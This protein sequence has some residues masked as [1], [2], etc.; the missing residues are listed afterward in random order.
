MKK[1]VIFTTIAT[2]I[3]LS[4]CNSGGATSSNSLQTNSTPPQVTSSNTNG[5]N[6]NW[7]NLNMNAPGSISAQTPQ[8]GNTSPIYKLQSDGVTPSYVVYTDSNNLYVYDSSKNGWNINLAT[9]PNKHGSFNH[10]SAG[11]N[12]IGGLATVVASTDQG[13]VYSYNYT[14]NIWSQLQGNGWGQLINTMDVAY[15][16]AGNL[17]NVVVGLASSKDDW[18]YG[19][20]EY[21]SPNGNAE[22]HGTGWQSNVNQ[23]S[24]NRDESGNVTNVVVGLNNGSVEA[25][26]GTLGSCADN[27]CWNELHNNGWRAAV[28]VMK[29]FFNSGSGQGIR[30]LVGLSN[31]AV[32]FY[33]S[34]LGNNWS[35]FQNSGWQSGVSYINTADNWE[36]QVGNSYSGSFV[37]GLNNGAIEY[38]NADSAHFTELHDSSWNS[39][40]NNLSAVW[41]GNLL[42]N[43]VIGLNN[44]AIEEYYA[45]FANLN[46]NKITQLLAATGNSGILITSF[47]KYGSLNSINNIRGDRNWYQYQNT[48]AYQINQDNQLSYQNFTSM[49]TDLFDQDIKNGN[50]SKYIDVNTGNNICDEETNASIVIPYVQTD[51]NITYG[52]STISVDTSSG[53][54]IKQAL[55]GYTTN[56]SNS[57]GQTINCTTPSITTTY[58]QTNSFTLTKG[59]QWNLG[60]T[61]SAAVEVGLSGIAK[62][63]GTISTTVSGGTSQ[64]TSDT[65]TT[66]TSTAISLASQTMPVSP[67]SGSSAT[68]MLTIANESGVATVHQPLTFNTNNNL[69]YGVWLYNS[70]TKSWTLASL[71]RN[72]ASELQDL[73]SQNMYSE[74]I[75]SESGLTVDL[76]SKTDYTANLLVSSQVVFESHP[77]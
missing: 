23:L 51:N 46:D 22:L 63:T 77:I 30:V 26:N 56:C 8:S 50:C 12:R 5:T 17:L 61:V 42:L 44:G 9:P 59:W 54:T 40:V 39:S 13:E 11:Y 65:A 2:S 72:L 47:D 3:L 4:A 35:E 16:N 1:T 69:N 36:S 29:V 37:V 48:D 18:H 33:S 32:E 7:V 20:V 68:V 45:P 25:W 64:S 10:I 43:L 19:G 6:V 34:S 62:V 27:S 21:L 38:W 57:T 31:G 58:T 75:N 73:G 66:Q 49:L 14:T 55:N 15:D 53:N 76:I 70:N 52:D 74:Y 71:S 67:N 60:A 24:V 28:N 41:N